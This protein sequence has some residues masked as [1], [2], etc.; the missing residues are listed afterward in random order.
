MDGFTVDDFYDWVIEP[1]LPLL[2]NLAPLD[3]GTV[4]TLQDFLYPATWFYTLRVVAGEL[5]PAPYT[6]SQDDDD[7]EPR[8]GVH[9]SDELCSRWPLFIPS[10]LEICAPRKEQIYSGI[11]SKVQLVGT[12]HIFFLKLV[13]RGDKKLAK[14]ELSNYEKIDDSGL[15]E[16]LRIS[17]LH[18]LVR[19][20]TG[21]VFGLLLT[22]I[23]CRALNLACALKSNVPLSLRRQ[24]AAQVESTVE[25]LHAA[26][27]IWGD[28]KAANVLIDINKEAWVADFGG[29]YTE[30][31]VDKESAGTVAGDLQGLAKI[32][33]F[34][35]V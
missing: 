5:A 12:N 8:Y 22:Y 35:G 6:T 27:I 24:W 3:S 34:L 25:R 20:E 17:R 15:D 23:D 30:G 32:I 11:P 1:F 9:L 2:R 7:D 26:G 19:D 29:G 13:G 18:G 16:E 4:S 31:W 10:K 33:D 28:A 14:R 21:Q